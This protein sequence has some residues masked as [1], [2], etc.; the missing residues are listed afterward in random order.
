M[1]SETLLVFASTCGFNMALERTLAS[2]FEDHRRMSGLSRRC[3]SVS[4][5]RASC[6]CFLP[7]SWVVSVC[8]S[9]AF[10]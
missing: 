6:R 2:L 3:N 5:F 8:F 4:L 10:E 7:D 1:Q 9:Y